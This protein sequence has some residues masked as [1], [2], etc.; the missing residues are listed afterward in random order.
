MREIQAL[1]DSMQ[2]VVADHM[3]YASVEESVMGPRAS[4]I[5]M[6]WLADQAEVIL[7]VE[8]TSVGGHTTDVMARITGNSNPGSPIGKLPRQHL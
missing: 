6:S 1:K 2:R 5:P 8:S 7:R 4:A 3:D